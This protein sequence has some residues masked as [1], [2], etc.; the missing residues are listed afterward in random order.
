MILKILRIRNGIHPNVRF[1][2]L[3]VKKKKYT[4][5]WIITDALSFTD[6]RMTRK[7]NRYDVIVDTETI[8]SFETSDIELMLSIIKAMQLAPKLRTKIFVLILCD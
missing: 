4:G 2:L 7:Y 1:S 8:F 6:F 5:A 3:I